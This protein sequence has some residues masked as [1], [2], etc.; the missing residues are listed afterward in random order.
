MNT[1][2]KTE[3]IKKFLGNCQRHA[4][5]YNTAGNNPKQLTSSCCFY[6]Y[7]F[8]LLLISQ[9]VGANPLE[10][11]QSQ[12]SPQSQPQDCEWTEIAA[13]ET[14][15]SPKL[16]AEHLLSLCRQSLSSEPEQTRI[17]RKSD[18][19]SPPQ[20]NKKTKAGTKYF[21]AIEIEEEYLERAKGAVRAEKKSEYMSTA[22]TYLILGGSLIAWNLKAIFGRASARDALE[23]QDEAPIGRWGRVHFLAS[24]IMS[25]IASSYLYAQIFGEDIRYALHWSRASLKSVLFSWFSGTPLQ[26]GEASVFIDLKLQYKALEIKYR[27]TQSKFP[28]PI[29]Q[30]IEM[31][32][33]YL[34]K[35]IREKESGGSAG[36]SRGQGDETTQVMAS[37]LKAVDTIMRLPLKLKEL[38]FSEAHQKLKKTL[39]T[40]PQDIQDAMMNLASGIEISSRPGHEN[41]LQRTIYLQGSPGTG[42]KT[43][44]RFF[45]KAFDLPVIELSLAQM[46]IND[47]S[48]TDPL[49]RPYK[50][51]KV[52]RL[53]NALASMEEGQRYKN[54]VVIIDQFDRTFKEQGQKTLAEETSSPDSFWLNFFDPEEKEKTLDDLSI[55]VDFSNYIFLLVGT[56]RITS[57]LLRTR[58]PTAHFGSF[59]LEQRV[60]IACQYLREKKGSLQVPEEDISALISAAEQ[61]NEQNLGITAL[62]RTIDTYVKQRQLCDT[63]SV[64]LDRNFCGRFNFSSDLLQHSHNLWSPLSQYELFKKRFERTQSLMADP[65]REAIQNH[66]FE[67]ENKGLLSS[68]AMKNADEKKAIMNYFRNLERLENL[69]RSSKPLSQNSKTIRERM[70]ASLKNYP[71]LVRNKVTQVVNSHINADR[72]PLGWRNILYLYGPPG[73]GK[74]HL[75]KKIAESTGLSLVHI[76]LADAKASDFSEQRPRI[77]FN[78]DSYLRPRRRGSM[79]ELDLSKLFEISRLSRAFMNEGS[80]PL[81][82]NAIIFLDEV[83]KILNEPNTGG[84]KQTMHHFLDPD[85]QSLVL[86]DFNVEIDI[87]KYL[88]ILAGND[89]LSA[90][91]LMDRVNVVEFKGYN[92]TQAKAIAWEKFKEFFAES[93]KADKRAC[94]E[95]DEQSETSSHYTTIASL[96]ENVC[97][98]G[99]CETEIDLRKVIPFVSSYYLQVLEMKGVLQ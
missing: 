17:F 10:L 99:T 30:A 44:A 20:E 33:D 93:C 24:M 79:E 72:V 59:G 41:I 23:A 40:Y 28:L 65:V 21:K 76:S 60:Q 52:S 26:N 3:K 83:D 53:S 12:N 47:F 14:R 42:K 64:F 55:K 97:L 5:P 94:L 63:E 91:S 50:D 4:N 43:L 85:K 74:T 9:A 18:P 15:E 71:D 38:S 73:T 87:R 8:P 81:E 57:D 90:K 27:E 69:P 6:F 32:L 77:D 56:H 86:P 80:V 84:L 11:C 45:A 19:I 95:S 35:I 34:S 92:Q 67:I 49:E 96:L 88:V 61:D 51:V 2:F 98:G 82:K 68:E 25:S 37:S 29:Q 78:L 48:G 31:R 62:T 7:F 75:A 16:V 54:A 58:L 22:A 89:K 70:T 39:A 1:S 66:L 13:P 46:S 36:E